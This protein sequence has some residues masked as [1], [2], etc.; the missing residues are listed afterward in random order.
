M[1]YCIILDFERNSIFKTSIFSI[2]IANVRFNKK[3]LEREKFSLKIHLICS[4]KYN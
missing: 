3:L 2:S 4:N 1:I